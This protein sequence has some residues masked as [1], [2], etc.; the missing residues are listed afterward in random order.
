MRHHCSNTNML[1]EIAMD[2][3]DLPKPKTVHVLGENL[4]AI[5]LEE[6]AR[7]IDALQAE[8][9]RIQREIEKKQASRF[10]ADAFFRS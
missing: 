1:P 2:P 5:S 6:L 8:I 7:R 4:D 9:S 3:D 10:A